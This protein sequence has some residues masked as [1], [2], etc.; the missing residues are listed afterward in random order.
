MTTIATASC[1]MPARKASPAA[2]HSMR[3]KKWK[4]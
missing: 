2:P 4:S 3:A 1:G